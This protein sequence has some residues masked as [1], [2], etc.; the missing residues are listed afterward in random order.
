MSVRRVQT[1]QA[2][3]D[4]QS[5]EVELAKR[6]YAR[7]PDGLGKTCS[8]RHGAIDERPFVIATRRRLRSRYV[9]EESRIRQKLRQI[10]TRRGKDQARHR[11]PRRTTNSRSRTT[12][13]HADVSGE[14]LR[15][16]C[17]ANRM[18]TR[19]RPQQGVASTRTRTSS[20]SK[21]RTSVIC[22]GAFDGLEKI[23]AG[24]PRRPASASAPTC[25]HA[26]SRTSGDLAR[27]E[28]DDQ[29]GLI[30]SSSPPAG[31]CASRS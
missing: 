19:I 22:G 12:V 24:V 3:E 20:R 1:L 4:S 7:G 29:Y 8:P 30:R 2:A 6:T 21:R 14:G 26:N 5:D 13:H 15:R 27:S 11:L 25:A 9:G 18:G 28:E 17:E 31:G 23:I 10:A 16:R